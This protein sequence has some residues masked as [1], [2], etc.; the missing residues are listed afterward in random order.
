MRS[1]AQS[2]SEREK[3][4]ACLDDLEQNS[5]KAHEESQFSYAPLREL[6]ALRGN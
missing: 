4:Q 5:R 2:D 1:A 6:Y 3:I